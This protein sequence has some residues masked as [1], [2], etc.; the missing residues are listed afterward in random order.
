MRLSTFY[1]LGQLIYR[2]RW[3][4]I[5]LW[6]VI[7]LACIPFTPNLISPFKTT[8]FVADNSK[9]A[10]TD[11]Y[12]NKNLGYINNN[13]IM[14]IYTS[15]QHSINNARDL[16][17]IK[18]SLS[19][20]SDFP[21]AHE[22]I[23]PDDK[24]PLSKN[25]HSTYVVVLFKNNEPLNANLLE[26]F[27]SLIKTPT[28]MTVQLGG[29]PLFIEEVNKQ[30][31]TDLF[32]A[33]LIAAPIAIIILL[34]V[35]GSVVA[36]LLPLILGGAC[37]LII[38]TTLFFLGHWFTLSI[39]TINIAMLL[40]L[41]LSL[42]YALFI[43]SRF[44]DELASRS[45]ISAK[46]T[47]SGKKVEDKL[48]R[49][50]IV[51]EALAITEATA[52]KAIFF[53]G[54]AV[55]ASL[56]ALL[57]FPVNILFS[58]AVGGMTA[59]VVA[60]LVAV[61]LLPAILGVLNTRINLLSIKL[62]RKKEGKSFNF[63]HWLAEKV[64]KRPW[65]YFF[66]ILIFLLML[67]YPILFAKFGVSDFRIF[68]PQSEHRLFF[69]LYDE[70]FNERELTPILVVV[71]TKP[72]GI[73]TRRNLNNLYDL[74]DK[75]KD[76]PSVKEVKSIV[77]SPGL[78]K[79]QY[80]NLYVKYKD[81]QDKSLKILLK[82]TTTNHATVLTVV[83]K[84]PAN[85]N[86]TKELIKQL[87][88]I[89]TAKGMSLRL[90]GSPVSN[91]ELLGSIAQKLPY[92]ILWIMVLTYLILLVLLR[93]LFLPLKAILMSILSLSACYGA[94]VMV[95]QEGYLHQLLNFEPQGSLDIS[96][97]VIIFCALFGFSMDYEVFLLT[98]IR[99]T[100]ELTGDNRKSI[101]WGIEKS[102][103]IITSAA[104][105][106]ICICGAFLVADGLMVK[107]FGLGIA[108]AIFVDAFLIRTILVP[109]TMILTRRWNWY[110]PK[111]LDKILPRI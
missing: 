30:T 95:F 38:L 18:Q 70:K 1:R 82:T 46:R 39:F 28:N 107:A 16:K 2:L 43:I 67:G 7:V 79:T 80:Y 101:V 99:E 102:S 4:I 94:L 42:D 48:F 15:K 27:K 50:S 6:I 104:I 54:L 25:K 89:K 22:I 56:S 31:Q 19:K 77:T 49:R 93:S 103:R 71:E 76:N 12:L 33:D 73:L 66:S 3:F 21:V 105:I 61:I 69:D 60:V 96:L 35:F 84:Y 26:K 52:G 44:R 11:H 36:A 14:I 45:S 13:Q 74:A 20:L 9:S 53:S 97:L 111:W 32:K 68:P 98:R 58:V 85:S 83:S 109:A 108:V 23:Y 29:E 86:E 75:I 72:S 88:E 34:L 91:N 81:M 17:K 87:R 110:L 51:A 8:G 57:L 65:L 37:A 55:F 24:K 64:V 41:C 40:G 90:T 106:V 100:Y 59:V 78:D 47:S 62:F 92:A 63:W 5:G 10:L